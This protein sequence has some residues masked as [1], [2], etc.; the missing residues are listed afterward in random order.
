MQP[1]RWISFLFV[2]LAWLPLAYAEI[3]Y[4]GWVNAGESFVV[5]GVNFTANFVASKNM[6]SLESPLGRQ[7]VHLGECKTSQ[8][9]EYCFQNVDTEKSIYKAGKEY[10]GLQITIERL[11]P[12]ISIERTFSTLAVELGERVDVLLKITNTGEKAALGVRYKETYPL[13][14]MVVTGTG[15]GFTKSK[16][17]VQWDGVLSPGKEVSF[18]YIIQPEGF[19]EYR[20]VGKLTYSVDEEEQSK[21]T[22]AALL[23][24][25][26]PFAL[27]DSF[28]PEKIEL[29][30]EIVYKVTLKNTINRAISIPSFLIKIPS[31]MHII[32][33]SKNLQEEGKNLLFQGEVSG[34]EEFEMKFSLPSKG[35]YDLILQLTVESQGKTF[36]KTITKP[37]RVGI[38][39]IIPHVDIPENVTSNQEF[40]LDAWLEN[41]GEEEVMVS[42]IEL[43]SPLV[44]GVRQRN[45]RMREGQKYKVFEKD[46]VAPRVV[47]PTPFT[48]ALQGNHLDEQNQSLPFKVEKTLQ[49]VPIA[50]ALEIKVKPD[51]SSVAVGSTLNVEVVVKNLKKYKIRDVEVAD[52]LPKHVNIVK[53]TPTATLEVEPE[54]EK[55]FY[56]Y[57]IAVL[58]DFTA[59]QIAI[60]TIANVELRNDI[61]YSTEKVT[62]VAVGEDILAEKKEEL[63]E[64]DAGE[65]SE[66]TGTGEETAIGEQKQGFFSRILGW[67]RGL[68]T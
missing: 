24:V 4:D 20:S 14:I 66:E 68:F 65:P 17:G 48:I 30:R 8:D 60:K 26:P 13:E 34:E 11:T 61:L 43:T 18:K 38:S 33:H 31:K 45:V 59:E 10:P 28:S 46:I 52:L 12:E 15:T 63:E 25:Q 5:N 9:G 23:F 56:V 58:E 42:F 36:T 7:I 41:I 35:E 64:D 22:E 44:S 2:L 50:D 55:V 67:L 53:G 27:E 32:R 6:L 62:T 1:M 37:I 57:T 29:G 16:H 51:K 39:Q 19:V 40:E 54:E 21:E 47:E 3:L 49:V